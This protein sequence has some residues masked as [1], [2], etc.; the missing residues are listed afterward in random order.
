MANE[1]Q[2]QSQKSYRHKSRAARTLP[3]PNKAS[4]ESVSTA[5]ETVNDLVTSLCRQQSTTEVA[6][7]EV[8]KTKQESSRESGNAWSLAIDSKLNELMERSKSFERERLEIESLREHQI[9]R[10]H[11]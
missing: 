3:I 10:A 6:I 7:T 2:Q 8:A 11:V 5:I 9:G 1:R 4:A